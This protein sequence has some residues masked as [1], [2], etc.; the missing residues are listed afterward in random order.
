MNN[1][2]GLIS[3]F[4]LDRSLGMPYDTVKY[5][6]YD[7]LD[8]GSSHVLSQFLLQYWDGTDTGEGLEAFSTCGSKVAKI[9]LAMSVVRRKTLFRPGHGA[10]REFSVKR[11]LL[12]KALA[13][14]RGNVSVEHGISQL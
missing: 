9:F 13:Y 6:T 10:E 2:L 1:K 3:E 12:E 14:P 11:N 4:F 7:E 8:C 5:A